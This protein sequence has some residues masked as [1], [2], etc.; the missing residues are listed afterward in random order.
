MVRL[1]DVRRKVVNQSGEESILRC[2]MASGVEVAALFVR[3]V[4]N[5]WAGRVN[6]L[7]RCALELGREVP[8]YYTS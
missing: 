1:R 6:M 3:V 8:V 7:V 2:M 5:G 4:F